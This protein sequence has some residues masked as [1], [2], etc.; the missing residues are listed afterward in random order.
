[1]LNSGDNGPQQSAVKSLWVELPPLRME[2]AIGARTSRPQHRTGRGLL[3]TRSLTRSPRAGKTAVVALDLLRPLSTA[4]ELM[5][6]F[7]PDR[8]CL[9]KR[10]RCFPHFQFRGFEVEQRRMRAEQDP[11]ARNLR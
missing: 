9:R 7:A 6:A 11:V 10:Q 5:R 2:P 8:A 1:M 4:Q 3:R